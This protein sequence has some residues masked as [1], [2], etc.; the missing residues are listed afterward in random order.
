MN[1]AHTDWF[2]DDSFWERNYAYLF[3]EGRF[4]AA[5]QEAANVLKLAGNEPRSVLDLC[6]G[7]GRHS[8]A[9]AKS[10]L[11]VTGVDRTNFLLNK[12]RTQ[13]A[14]GQ[15]DAEWIESDM[16][17]FRR[18]ASFD[19]AINLFTSFGYFEDDAENRKV[20]ANVFESLRDGGVF[21]MDTLGKEPF[22]R[23]FQPTGADEIPGVGWM[24]QKRIVSDDWTRVTVEAML[25][26]DESVDRFG[27]RH[28]LYSGQE[29][30]EMLLSAGFR[31][32]KL[33]G[34]LDGSEYGADAKRLVA[35]ARR[36]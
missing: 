16:R 6:C 1:K 12:A 2:A 3:P 24:V 15:V 22:A 13:A 20:L 19:L 14:A 36:T 28:W 9:L 29:L 35:V 30:K 23:I 11:R 21:V 34:S 7:P 32:V 25:I 18:P 5:A 17:E 27:F 26:R 33:Y 31:D 8:I 4:A 10:G